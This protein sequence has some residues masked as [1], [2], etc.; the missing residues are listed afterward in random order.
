MVRQP[1]LS[2]KGF[3]SFLILHELGRASRCGEELAILIGKRKGTKLTPGTIYPALKRLRQLRLVTFNQEGTRKAYALTP[4]GKR[5]LKRLS[6]LFSTYFAGIK[7][8]RRSAGAR[9]K[10]EKKSFS[11]SSPRDRAPGKRR[12]VRRAR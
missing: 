10:K 3:L 4:R 6:E 2:L 12:P 5:E 7:T 9:R 1:I 8:R 11:R